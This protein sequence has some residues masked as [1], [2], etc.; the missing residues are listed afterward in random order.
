[1]HTAPV[2]RCGCPAGGPVV[3][4]DGKQPVLARRVL[5]AQDF[6]GDGEIAVR[7]Q[8]LAGLRVAMRVVAEIDLAETGVDAIV[9]RVGEGPVHPP[10]GLGAGG[11]VLRRSGDEIGKASWWDRVCQSVEN[12]WGDVSLK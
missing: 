7:V 2:A 12:P 4:A 11:I 9:R 10:A 1:M 8:Q 3:A 5:F 6:R